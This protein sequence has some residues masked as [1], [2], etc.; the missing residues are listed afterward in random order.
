MLRYSSVLRSNAVRHREISYNALTPKPGRGKKKSL[1]PQRLRLGFEQ[2]MALLMPY[3][4]VRVLEQMKAVIPLALYLVLFQLVI[5]RQ[6]I[7]A[8]LLLVGGLSAVIVG[9]ALFMEGLNVGLMPFG[10]LIGDKLPRKASMPVMML[11][12]AVLGVGVTFAEPAIGALQAFGASVD[13]TRA[14]Y[15]YEILNNWT[16]P[17]VLLVG[18]GVG[19]AAVLGT[20]RFVKGW[21][22][23]PMIYIAVGL[24]LCLTLVVYA[25]NDLRAV[26]GLAWDCG[27]VTTG[28]VTVPL[29][30]SLGIGIAN[31]TGQS[32]D[33][34]LSGFGVVTLASLFPIIAVLLLSLYV[35]SQISA[36]QIVI[37]AATTDSAADLVQQS[38]WN[39]SPLQEI[40]LG[41]RAIAPLVLFLM[42][43][44]FIVLREGLANK[45]FTAYGLVLSI[46]GMCVFNVGLT[47][48]LG[49]IGAQTGAILPAAFMEVSISDISPIY[50]A[51]LGLVLVI[52]FA[53]FMGFGATLAEP[54]LNA[55][56]LTVQNLTNGAFRKSMLMYSVATGV[57]FG[58][59]LGMAKILFE[60]DLA[61]LLI[62][63]YLIALVLTY[64]S[65]EE[66]VN[67]AWDSAGVTTG[68]VTVPLVL[69]M[70]LGLGNAVSA[71]EG[72][73][74]LSMASIGPIIAV[75]GMGQYIRF[76]QS[77]AFA[78]E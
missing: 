14:P 42:F 32:S 74:I 65:T 2:T 39:A 68:P 62:P 46:V 47:Y 24:T 55:L 19:L 59:A 71:I 66:F 37:A 40:V 11:I 53:W 7:E 52:L 17:L 34:S 26:L 64:F 44:L 72:F 18:A 16:L 12:I 5:L 45:L 6:P 9:L 60:I 63:L 13:V 48:G 25:N 51:A 3:S 69:A 31:S 56:G 50:S 15:L 29:V 35:S 8:A 73:G 30:L 78:A 28:P 10:T 27:A 76:K 49:A 33:N 67:V 21:S 57:A 43:V 41:V 54:A 58:I 61:M 22:L 23:K 36:E 1:K 75:L 4:G 20:L 77:R 70:G 38:M